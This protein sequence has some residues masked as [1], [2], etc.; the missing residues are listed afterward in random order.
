MTLKKDLTSNPS[1]NKA[2]TNITNNAK[3]INLNEMF[4]GN[5][6]RNL[7]IP[8]ASNFGTLEAPNSLIHKPRIMP[9]NSDNKGSHTK[10]SVNSNFVNKPS[11]KFSK[12]SSDPFSSGNRKKSNFV[13][14]YQAGG[15]PC[16]IIHGSVR[17]KLSWDIP[18]ESI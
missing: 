3:K 17:L 12:K 13:Y 14:V 9:S 6:N 2:N 10:I 5:S 18:P 15:I 4:I 11:D 8:K 16:R 1:S 7:I